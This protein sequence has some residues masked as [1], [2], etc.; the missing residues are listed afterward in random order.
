MVVPSP[1][2]PR[3]YSAEEYLEAEQVAA[4]RSEFVRGHVYAMAGGSFTHNRINVNI[5]KELAVRLDG[6]DCEP[7]ASDLRVRVSSM[8]SFFY[9]DAAVLCGPPR[10]Y[11]S[12]QDTIE[13]PTVVFEI[14]SD[15]TEKYDR[16]QKFHAYQTI[17]DLR[18]YVLVSQSE[19]LVEVFS[20]QSDFWVLRTYRGVDAVAD[21]PAIGIQVPC[22]QIYKRVQFSSSSP[23]LPALEQSQG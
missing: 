4:Y 17:P 7:I 3:I 15:S 2:T 10:F 12:R 14:L 11:A 5:L 6:G 1:N 20:K 9:P 22:D 18:H 13:N 19:P 21:F 8:A 23:S 16:G